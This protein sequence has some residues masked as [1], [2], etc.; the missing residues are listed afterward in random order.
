MSF[1]RSLTSFPRSKTTGRI[2]NS[3]SLSAAKR[4][5]GPLPIM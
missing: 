2:P 3:M 4:P 1:L 5:A